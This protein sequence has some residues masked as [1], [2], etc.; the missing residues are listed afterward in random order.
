MADYKGL[1]AHSWPSAEFSGDVSYLKACIELY[2][3]DT[4]IKSERVLGTEF[5][6]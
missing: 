3:P 6:I 5:V 1:E 4:E 2:S